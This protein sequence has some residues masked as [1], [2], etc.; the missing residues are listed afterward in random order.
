M[1]AFYSHGPARYGSGNVEE[2]LAKFDAAW[3]PPGWILVEILDE[4]FH[5]IAPKWMVYKGKSHYKII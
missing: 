4:G 2:G 3:I 5:K 1:I